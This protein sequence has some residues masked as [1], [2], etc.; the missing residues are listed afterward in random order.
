MDCNT[1]ADAGDNLASASFI[2]QPLIIVQNETWD[3]AIVTT[4]K[5]RSNFINITNIYNYYDK[6]TSYNRVLSICRSW[7]NNSLDNINITNN[8]CSNKGKNK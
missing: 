4:I 3:R 7:T 6:R 5:Q 8:I 2:Y 1:I